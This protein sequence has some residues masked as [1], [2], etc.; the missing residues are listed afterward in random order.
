MMIEMDVLRGGDDL[1]RSRP[2]LACTTITSL[3]IAKQE[4][5]YVQWTPHFTLLWTHACEYDNFVRDK[6]V[7]SEH[8]LTIFLSLDV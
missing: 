2:H 1:T 8:Q 4:A 3:E 6:C 5:T 7:M